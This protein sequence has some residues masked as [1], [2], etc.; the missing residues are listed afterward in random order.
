ME[1]KNITKLYRG[2]S[3]DNGHWI[4]GGVYIEQETSTAF[5][6]SNINSSIGTAYKVFYN[7]V[8]QYTGLNDKNNSKIFEGDILLFGDKRLTVWWNGEAF[9][10]QAK[11]KNKAEI[12]YD[13]LISNYSYWDNIDLG[14]IAA[15]VPILGEMSTEII[16]NIYES[17]WK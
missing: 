8:G 4:Y 9:Q 12:T 13:N 16:G 14:Y 1:N 11:E 2:I 3:T 5:I 15:E 17:Y 6:I 7:T 10:W